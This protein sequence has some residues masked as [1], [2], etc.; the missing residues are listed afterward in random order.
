MEIFSFNLI[1][2]GIVI[3]ILSV[4]RYLDKNNRSLEK[5]KR[6]SDKEQ[7][8]LAGF[9]DSTTREIQNLAIELDVNLKTGKEILKRI[10]DSE[11]ELAGRAESFE[12]VRSKITEYDTLI[13]ELNGATVTVEENIKKIRE[14]SSFVTSVSKQVKAARAELSEVATSIPVLRE[15]LC[16]KTASDAAAEKSKVFDEI[17]QRMTGFRQETAL[18]EK[19]LKDY[20]GFMTRLEAKSQTVETDMAKAVDAKV[21]ECGL[22][23]AGIRDKA[24]ADFSSGVEAVIAKAAEA[25]NALASEIEDSIASTRDGMESVKDEFEAALDLFRNEVSAIE[26]GMAASLEDAR[27]K[28]KDLEREMLEGCKGSITKNSEDLKKRFEEKYAALNHEFDTKMKAIAGE[29]ESKLKKFGEGLDLA[30][31]NT[32]ST[33]GAKHAEAVLAAESAMKAFAIGNDVKLKELEAGL[34]LDIRKSL[35]RSSDKYAEIEAAMDAFMEETAKKQA[36]AAAELDAVMKKEVERVDAMYAEVESSM[37]AFV[38]ETSKKQAEQ[39]AKLDTAA[40]KAVERVDDV[41]AELKSSVDSFMEET[42]KKQAEHSAELDA[43]AEKA[44]ERLEL[45][46]AEIESSVESFLGETAKKQAEQEAELDTAARKAAERVELRYA[47][48]EAAID[49]FM[50]ETAGRERQFE[51]GIESAIKKTAEKIEEK[52]ALMGVE[53][54][55]KVKMFVNE[56]T[57]RQKELE[58]NLELSVKSSVE[59]A[60][61]R[62]AEIEAVMN[63]FVNETSKKQRE[64]EAGFDLSAKK[65]MGR[66]EEIGKEMLEREEKLAEESKRVESVSNEIRKKYADVRLEFEQNAAG[67]RQNIVELKTGLYGEIMEASSEIEIK[68]MKRIEKQLSDYENDLGYR[69]KKLEDT[70]VDIDRLDSVMKESVE[71]KKEEIRNHLLLF[72]RDLEEKALSEKSEHA[73]ILAEMAESITALDGEVTELKSKAYREVS[74]KLKLFEDSFFSDLKTRQETIDRSLVKWESDISSTCAEKLSAFDEIASVFERDAK[75]RKEELAAVLSG[76]D[77]DM[78]AVRSEM[79]RLTE[80][81]SKDFAERVSIMGDGIERDVATRGEKIENRIDEWEKDLRKTLENKTY[82]FEELVIDFENAVKEKRA[83]QEKIVRELG[84]GLEGVH[85]ELGAFRDKAYRDFTERASMF[86]DGFMADLKSRSEKIEAGM[87]SW[88][89]T[90]D[91]GIEKKIRDFEKGI[92]EK[93]A[94]YEAEWIKLINTKLGG[95]NERFLSVQNQFDEYYDRLKKEMDVIE[96]KQAYLVSQNQKIDKASQFIGRLD[97]ELQAIRKEMDEIEPQRKRLSALEEEYVR[98][99][100]LSADLAKKVE[101]SSETTAAKLKAIRSEMEKEKV[102][103]SSFVNTVDETMEGYRESFTAKLEALV[104]DT[105]KRLDELARRASV[106]IESLKDD[107]ASQRDELVAATSEDRNTIMRELDEMGRKVDSLSVRVDDDVKNALEQFKAEMAS[108]EAGYSAKAKS[109]EGAIDSKIV[110]F[111]RTMRDD[112]EKIKSLSERWFG[113]I[114]TDYKTLLANFNEIDKQQKN[115]ESQTRLFERADKLKLELKAEIEELKKDLALIEPERKKM[116]AVETELRKTQ[117]ATTEVTGKMARFFAEKSKI[118][119]MEKNIRQL[120]KLSESVEKRLESVTA[121]HDVLE[122]IELK[123]RSI[124]ELEQKTETQ[125]ERLE[126]KNKVIETTTREVE[127]NFRQLDDLEKHVK[128]IDESVMSFPAKITGISDQIKFLAENKQKADAAIEQVGK[129]NEVLSDLED[130]MQKLQVAREWLS[131]TETRLETI[132]KNAGEQLN[133]LKTI[134]KDDGGSEGKKGKG[135]PSYDTRQM[136]VKLA[137]QG[138]A[139]KEIAK[140]SNVSQGEVELILELEPQKR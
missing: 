51:S 65:S 86:E 130:R 66:L 70:S 36:E 100:T 140:A 19:K 22:A 28:S 20:A 82:E 26:D 127:N 3:L 78:R 44:V 23:V 134:M 107:F 7:E 35:E 123:L 40:R 76:L 57:H 83:E 39:A 97:M 81:T 63:A 54:E 42:S 124:Y 102:G 46:Y 119:E 59:R 118:D 117:K 88:Q 12:S 93:Y 125:F 103:I 111:S 2:I 121:N 75:S 135:A 91:S 133:L 120:M 18:L 17:G 64:F 84:D 11:A 67:L 49:D 60:E 33:F 29:N 89:K 112:H 4:F 132:A 95:V 52:L 128:R 15:Q 105:D 37:D 85:R 45:R 80:S 43:F 61:A 68:I 34:E 74:E 87:D 109:F 62:R 10:A 73:R 137:R 115:F 116:N 106:S 31:S 69:L 14:E 90:V 92:E 48:A 47:E 104:A 50:K 122:E 24:A 136:I 53:Y 110:E 8:K 94:G 21:A 13:E 114:E 16:R 108:V 55:S 58:A 126:K 25:K 32:I 1:T 139:V 98:M 129:I 131:K 99:Q 71:S 27:K 101:E 6:F 79:E 113:R 72:A 138:W 9:I 38:E 56:A 96:K 41:Y 5:V 30:I 77:D